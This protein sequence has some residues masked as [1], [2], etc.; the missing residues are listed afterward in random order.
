MSGLDVFGFV[1]GALSVWLCVRKNVWNWPV[2]IANS[3]VFLVSF[4]T[5][6]LFADAGLQVVYVVLGVYGWVYWLRGGANAHE[7][8]VT[9]AGGLALVAA[10]AFVAVATW[11]FASVLA[12][13]FHSTVPL[14]DGLTTA[15]SLAA[16][17]LLSR[18]VLENWFFWIAADVVYVPLYFVK[19]LPLTALLY[20]IFLG[21]CV[22]GVVTWNRSLRAQPALA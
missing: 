8:P 2:G 18:K 4:A 22:A 17:F 9:R 1:T 6:G 15:L 11:A 10:L 12:A 13:Y 21:M 7:A 3:L 5:V 19:G 14:W 16:Q 20:V